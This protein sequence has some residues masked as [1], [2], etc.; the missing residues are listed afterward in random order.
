[1]FN[2]HHLLV[3]IETPYL[4]SRLCFIDMI[5]DMQL[6]AKFRGFIQTSDEKRIP[7]HTYKIQ[8]KQSEIGHRFWRVFTYIDTRNNILESERWETTCTREHMSKGITYKRYKPIRFCLNSQWYLY[9]TTVTVNNKT[10]KLA[11]FVYHVMAPN[12]SRK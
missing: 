5:N 6:Y 10:C 1:M 8:Y 4:T 11:L 3:N 2:G 7:T 12:T 9:T